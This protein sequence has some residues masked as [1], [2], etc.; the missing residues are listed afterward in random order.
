[1]KT[2]GHL[3]KFEHTY[4]NGYEP[5][6]YTLVVGNERI[7]LNPWIG[8][9]IRI[10]FLNEIACTACGRITNKSFNSG[11]CYPCFK[12]L[13]ENDLCIVKPH[14]C[15]YHL[16]TCRDSSFGDT[17]C[18]KPHYVYLALSSDV[19]VGLTRKTNVPKRWIDQGA[20][21]AIPIAELPT[22][23]MAGEL[24]F[25]L[26][27]VLPDKTNWRKMLKGEVE[28]TNLF[29]VRDTILEHV[30]M[31]FRSY[32][33]DETELVELM[34]PI[35]EELD[36][37]KSISLDKEQIVQGKLIGIKGQYL[38]MDHG[39]FHIGKHTGYKVEIERKELSSEAKI[40]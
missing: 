1:M 19:K 3:A 12:S 32:L 31:E 15:H 35:L 7:D 17:F 8:E 33:L 2:I 34:Y 25:V 24:E 29:E 10:S 14:E 21:H 13:P 11:Y 4:E 16:G 9:Q 18:M 28:M 30:P 37:I 39:V 22:R 40:S 38:L 36:K 6:Q 26:S 23:K 20:I 5:V 27:Q